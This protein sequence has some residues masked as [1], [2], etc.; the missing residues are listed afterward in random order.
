[1]KLIPFVVGLLVATGVFGESFFANGIL[2][3]ATAYAVR[4]ESKS[5]ASFSGSFK[6]APSEDAIASVSFSVVTDQD[7]D[8]RDDPKN[9]HKIYPQMQKFGLDFFVYMG[10]IEY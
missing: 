4:V 2:K 10:D 3:P 6:T 9:G 1:M 8:R 7:F 5:G